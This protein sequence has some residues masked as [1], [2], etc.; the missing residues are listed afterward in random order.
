MTVYIF[1]TVNEVA[2]FT[3][4]NLLLIAMYQI[5]LIII[6]FTGSIGYN[7]N[8]LTVSTQSNHTMRFG[9]VIVNRI[10]GIK[11]IHVACDFNLQLTIEY[12]I[13]FFTRMP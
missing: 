6:G 4:N 5:T 3:D 1:F 7:S 9:T 12:V 2:V 10:A 11:Y 8:K 13:K